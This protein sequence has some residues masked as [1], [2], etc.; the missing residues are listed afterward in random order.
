VGRRIYRWKHI[1]NGTFLWTVE[2]LLRLLCS[3]PRYFEFSKRS[4]AR[5]GKSSKPSGTVII[6]VNGNVLV[7]ADSYLIPKT[8]W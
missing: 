2:K 8:K 3:I 5:G 7:C 6:T 4:T 1:P